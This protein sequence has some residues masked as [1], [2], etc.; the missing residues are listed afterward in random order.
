MKII[1]DMRTPL[2]DYSKFD[3]EIKVE[4]LSKDK[5]A[6]V[7]SNV[8]G[9]KVKEII[10]KEDKDKKIA[11]IKKEREE[12]KQLIDYKEVYPLSKQNK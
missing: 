7:Y 1:I 4:E 9:N 3:R 6:I 11:E 5:I 8:R 2:F 12:F 10:K